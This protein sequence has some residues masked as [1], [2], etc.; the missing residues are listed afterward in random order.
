[1]TTTAE[2][3]REAAEERP[4][5][6]D[7]W[8]WVKL[9][10]VC[11]FVRGVTFDKSDATTFERPET[12]PILR[13]GNIAGQLKLSEDLMWVSASCVSKEQL[14]RVGDIAIC[15]SS[16]SPAVVGKTAQLK[17]RWQGSVGAFCGIIRPRVAESAEYFGFW[18]R[19]ADFIEWRNG[20]ARGA[21]I[22]NLRFSEIEKIELPLPPLAEQKRIAGILNEQMAAVERARRSAEAQLQAAEALPAARLRT[23]FSSPDAQAW[24][25][26]RMGD[27]AAERLIGLVRSTAELSPLARYPYLKMENI[28]ADG[29][30][31]FTTTARVEATD[32]EKKRHTL[33]KGDFLFNTRNSFELVGKTG[34]FDLDED[35]WVFNNNIMRVRFN[36]DFN[37]FFILMAF[38]SDEVVTQ[39]ESLKSN[40]T[41]V[42][43]I[44]DRQFVE[45]TIPV[46]PL[47]EQHRIASQL[48]AQ[49]S[50]AERLRQTLAEQLDAINHLPA[51]LLRKAFSGRI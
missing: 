25:R 45:L 47:S 6:P 11:E 2:I 35:D 39:M 36:P 10:E 21:N 12:L 7:G 32:E 20:Q 26:M 46:P 37:P 30:L 22:Q 42:C 23:V 40:T 5:L 43:A 50:S 27:I 18:F 38:H 44:Y 51:A 17:Q 15:M 14:F 29:R 3:S 1:M 9:V 24:P 8:R 16:G 19:S 49:M 4:Q 13:A 34:V 41:S 28:T 48:S 31:V 33:R